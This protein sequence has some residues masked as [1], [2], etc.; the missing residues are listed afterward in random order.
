MNII[1]R[2]FIKGL[3]L[4]TPLAGTVLIL[5]WLFS[6]LEGWARSALNAWLPEEFLFPGIGIFV[7]LAMI[8]LVG[9][10]AHFWG[11]SSLIRLLERAMEK[12]PLVKAVYGS[13]KDFSDFMYPSSPEKKKLGKSVMVHSE[14][15]GMSMVGFEMVSD[16]REHRLGAK[17]ERSKE[18]VAVYL[19]MSYQ[20]GGYMVIVDREEVEPLDL[21][22][23]ETLRLT[24][25][26]G[27]TG[28]SQENRK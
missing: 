4:L 10:L 22:A 27:V 17:L 18:K 15:L 25:T 9:V 26:A 24:M 13:L 6:T 23:E 7:F 8:F 21:S 16:V 20:L 3:A 28:S 11:F 14:K 5:Y 19:P 2:I 12:A 1:S